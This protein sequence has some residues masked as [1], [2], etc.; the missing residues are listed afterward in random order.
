MKKNDNQNCTFRK[1]KWRWLCVVVGIISLLVIFAGGITG[2]M[3]G[4]ANFSTPSV[5]VIGGADGPTA[6]YV[7][8][9]PGTDAG[10]IVIACILLIASIFGFYK[11]S[12]LKK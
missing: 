8:A 10:S 6:I 3:S 5:G 9:T 4:F 12:N 11:L 2:I 7:S 1:S